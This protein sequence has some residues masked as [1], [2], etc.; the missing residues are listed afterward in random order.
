[1]TGRLEF[2]SIEKDFKYSEDLLGPI[3]ENGKIDVEE[4][5]KTKTD[6]MKNIKERLGQ[7]NENEIVAFTDGSSLW[8]PGPTGAS[9]EVYLKGYQSSL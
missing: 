1:M 5:K 6:Q 9:A 8:N 2:D 3:K 7:K 4:F